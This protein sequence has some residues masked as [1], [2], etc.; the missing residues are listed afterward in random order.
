MPNGSIK[1]WGFAAPPFV[2]VRD[3]NSHHT[4][5]DENQDNPQGSIIIDW[6]LQNKICLVNSCMATHIYAGGASLLDIYITCSDLFVD[7]KYDI[8]PDTF[9]S[10]HCQIKLQFD[11][12]TTG[13]ACHSIR[14]RYDWGATTRHLNQAVL[15]LHNN[16]YENFQLLFFSQDEWPQDEYSWSWWDSQ[17][18]FLLGQKK[19][20]QKVRKF[21]CPLI[22]IQKGCSN[23]KEK[24]N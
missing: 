19:L 9:D 18:S 13:P 1:F 17:C 5:L 14:Y 6:I 8:Y 12:N 2:I 20:L 21:L 4:T 15:N 24:N 11:I 7:T 3:F 23:P 22:F 16:S 10:D